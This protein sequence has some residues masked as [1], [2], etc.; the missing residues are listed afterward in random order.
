[1]P[2]GGII[3]LDLKKLFYNRFIMRYFSILLL[4]FAVGFLFSCKKK[5]EP[6]KVYRLTPEDI[7]WNIYHMSDTIKLLSN[8]NHYRAYCV[9]FIIQDINN[10]NEYDSWDSYES[11]GIGFQRLD[12][13][14]ENN[15]FS[16]EIARG[17]PGDPDKGLLIFIFWHDDLLLPSIMDFEEF[18][19]LDTLKINN[20]VYNNVLKYTNYRNTDSISAAKHLYYQ[21]Q[22]GWLRIELNSGEIYNR[23]N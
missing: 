17:Y 14:F 18:V 16:M 4:I 7:S 12:S 5:E 1:M 15:H 8:H 23:I 3:W 6:K 20:V 21:K 22:K 10:P 2:V 13:I 11:I 9:D 19:A